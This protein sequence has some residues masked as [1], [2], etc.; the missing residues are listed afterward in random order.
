MP[1]NMFKT[2]TRVF[3]GPSEVAGQYRIYLYLC[4]SVALTVSTI[5]STRMNL[6]MAKISVHPRFQ[7]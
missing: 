7:A 5:H 2:R 4:W 3:I 1:K 6:I